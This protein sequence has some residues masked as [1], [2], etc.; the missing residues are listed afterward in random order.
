MAGEAIRPAGELLFFDA[1]GWYIHPLGGT[2]GWIAPMPVSGT[3]HGRFGAKGDKVY[4]NKDRS[5]TELDLGSGATRSFPFPDGYDW[6]VEQGGVLFTDTAA[7]GVLQR[8]DLAT[9]QVVGVGALPALEP[10]IVP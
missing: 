2:N 10:Y 6:T 3:G 8:L 9:G 7:P 4:F 5:L 1:T